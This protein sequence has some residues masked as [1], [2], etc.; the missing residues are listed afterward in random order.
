[1]SETNKHIGSRI[2]DSVLEGNDDLTRNLVRD[3]SY[4]KTRKIL[5]L[6][7]E[8]Q[9]TIRGNDI[10]VGGNTVGS[11]ETKDDKIQFTSSSDGSVHTFENDEEL[12]Q[13]VAGLKEEFKTPK[14]DTPKIS[15][16]GSSSVT[17]PEGYDSH[18]LKSKHNDARMENPKKNDHGHDSTQSQ[19]SSSG[20]G[21]NPPD[22]QT[23]LKSKHKDDRMENPKKHD[24]GH[25]AEQNEP[26]ASG[27][28][29]NPPDKQTELKAHEH[30]PNSKGH[31]HDD[32]SGV[33]TVEKKGKK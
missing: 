28:G 14:I 21:S 26:L 5:G 10:F 18:E 25:D 17:P 13:H 31:K 4:V 1:M 27:G 32:P 2:V 24:H 33:G 20:G 12:M 15:S 30:T 9:V 22:K 23:E 7:E 3:M 6:Y 11:F 29:S 8:D 16:D 19:P